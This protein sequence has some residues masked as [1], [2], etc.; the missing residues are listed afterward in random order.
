MTNDEYQRLKK[1]LSEYERKSALLETLSIARSNCSR[2]TIVVKERVVVVGSTTVLVGEE[3]IKEI[4]VL[5]DNSVC[6]QEKLLT[7]ERDEI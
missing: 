4:R 1:R 2:D 7:K 6:D 3:R 5:V